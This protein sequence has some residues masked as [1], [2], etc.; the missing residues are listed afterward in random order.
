[1]P[2]QN[3]LDKGLGVQLAI[4]GIFQLKDDTQLVAGILD[5]TTELERTKRTG[6]DAFRP[7][8]TSGLI[9]ICAGAI[10]QISYRNDTESI[11]TEEK[12]SLGRNERGK[13][14][15]RKENGE[16]DEK[17]DGGANNTRA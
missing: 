11:G 7:G 4:T 16:T 9:G 8:P 3:K 10:R 13:A 15:E 1:M 6:R 14:E 2:V 5:V 12:C 17:S